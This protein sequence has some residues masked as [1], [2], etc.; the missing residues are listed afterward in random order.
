MFRRHGS[1][2]CPD[3]ILTRQTF[4]RQQIEDGKYRGYSRQ[5][6]VSHTVCAVARRDIE[7]AK[8]GYYIPQDRHNVRRRSVIMSEKGFDRF[9]RELSEEHRTCAD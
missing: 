9:V 5:V 6:T 3:T 1:Q 7:L 2:V 4:T 8:H